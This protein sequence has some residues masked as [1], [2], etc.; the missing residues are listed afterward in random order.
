MH[1]LQTG[2]RYEQ[3]SYPPLLFVRLVQMDWHRYLI[4]MIAWKKY[5][6]SSE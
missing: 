4:T 3:E 2:L 5:R 6:V 1:D